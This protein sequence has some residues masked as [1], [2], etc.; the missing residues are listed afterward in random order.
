MPL[1]TYPYTA[2]RISC[3]NNIILKFYTIII[4]LLYYTESLF[5]FYVQKKDKVNRLVSIWGS[6]CIFYLKRRQT[7]IPQSL[8]FCDFMSVQCLWSRKPAASLQ[9]HGRGS[10][11]MAAL[12]TW[13]RAWRS[14]LAPCFILLF[15]SSRV[16]Y[17]LEAKG[18]A[19]QDIESALRIFSL[20]NRPLHCG[21]W[22]EWGVD[23]AESMHLLLH[24][25]VELVGLA[26]SLSLGCQPVGVTGSESSCLR[27]PLPQ[28][29][30]WN[31]VP[32]C[33]P[34]VCFCCRPPSNKTKDW[35]RADWKD[36]LMVCVWQRDWNQGAIWR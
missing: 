9:S 11:V 30:N 6:C 12:G 17:E 23:D 7:N 15:S 13:N 1:V 26:C 16:F 32:E 35:L 34:V 27:R 25:K 19:S 5:H 2:Q 22:R 8:S 28:L 31:R 14:I 21:G 10:T 4:L 24:S 29:C 33:Q 20:I 3:Y 18:A 36:G